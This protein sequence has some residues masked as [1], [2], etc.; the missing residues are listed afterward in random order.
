MNDEQTYTQEDLEAG[1]LMFARAW[2]FLTS[3]T[4]MSNLPDAAGTEIAFAGRSNVGK[5]SLINAL[6]GRKGLARTSSTPG[7][8]QMLNFFIA[9]DTPLTIVDMP[10]YGYAQAPKELVEAWTQLVF[11][12]L[13]GRP[14]LRRV[15]L[16]IDSRHGI[17]KNDLE[18]MDL[19]D[20]AAVVYQVVL[21]KSDKI[22]PTQLARLISD[23]QALLAKRIAAHPLIVATSSEKNLGIDELRAELCL[24]ANQ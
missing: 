6:T 13:R 11:S 9:P 2:D 3:V 19:L 5:S 7:R 10:G 23:T 24:L 15:I 20:K 21:T 14:N 1:R 18:A 22:K 8:T 16:L 4:D 17:K 12:Y